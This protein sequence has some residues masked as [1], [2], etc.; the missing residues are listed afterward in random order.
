MSLRVCMSVSSVRLL[1]L[2]WPHCRGKCPPEAAIPLLEGKSLAW[3]KIAGIDFVPIALKSSRPEDIASLI[4]SIHASFPCVCL[5]CMAEDTCLKIQKELLTG[6]SPALVKEGSDPSSVIAVAAIMNA[7]K[8]LHKEW[9]HL[10]VV[11]IG[12]HAANMRIVRLLVDGGVDRAGIA[13]C[14]GGG[15]K[16]FRDGSEVPAELRE[17][18]DLLVTPASTDASAAA[19]SA[20]S[21]PGAG[22]RV[23]T[24]LSDCLT[25]ADIVICQTLEGNVVRLEKAWFA[26]LGENAMLMS[27]SSPEAEFV[28]AEARSAGVKIVCCPRQDAPNCV[29]PSYVMPAMALAA[30]KLESKVWGD[31]AL[32]AAADRLARYWEQSGGMKADA[33][34]PPFE[35]VRGI[36][37]IVVGLVAGSPAVEGV[38]ALPE[39]D[40]RKWVRE[41]QD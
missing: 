14:D 23:Q 25:G 24:S 36:E 5:S 33:V 30:M 19:D 21:P 28:E 29:S 11:L 2:P 37:E 4:R 31:R 26:C 3:H 17:F 13:V 32:L 6:P 12:F 34:V 10:R 39:E 22:G 40:L 9:N 7:A 35:D 20:S 18:A 16:L 41:V 8:I 15:K 1:M 27:L 38:P